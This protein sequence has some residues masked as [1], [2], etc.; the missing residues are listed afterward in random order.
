L[1]RASLDQADD[2]GAGCSSDVPDAD[3][4]S[5]GKEEIVKCKLI[6]QTIHLNMWKFVALLIVGVAIASEYDSDVYE[7][8]LKSY[9]KFYNS[10]DEYDIRYTNFNANL[11][12]ILKHNTNPDRTWNMGLGEFTDWSFEEFQERRLMVAQNCSATNG[13]DLSGIEYP[14]D[15]FDW[16]D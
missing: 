11:K 5:Y 13:A 2:G 10:Q 7:A 14:L 4:E 16:R 12:T 8:Y 9:H 1:R 3:T 15:S 6:D